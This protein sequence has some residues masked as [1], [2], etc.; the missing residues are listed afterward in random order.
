ML[1][2]ELQNRQ[3]DLQRVFHELSGS[4]E[5]VPCN[6]HT[7]KNGEA[8]VTF[9]H[10]V[11]V[12]SAGLRFIIWEEFRDLDTAPYL[13]AFKY[14]V[15]EENDVFSSQPLFRYECH[16]DVGDPVLATDHVSGNSDFNSPYETEPHFHPDNTVGERMRKL[17][18]PFHRNE[19]K[20]IVFALIKWL[21]VDLVRR[22]YHV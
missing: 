3:R 8:V 14:H 1:P 20:T 22:F 12:R 15:S 7:L 4:V 17:H 13:Y 5:Y 2:P 18:Y 9:T 10:S 11:R 19:R 6:E 21:R 16:P